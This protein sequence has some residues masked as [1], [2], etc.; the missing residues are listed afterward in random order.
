MFF[1]GSRY[2][3]LTT[4]QVT[5]ADG[6]TVTVTQLP[7]PSNPPL[8][9]AYP[10]QNGQRLDLIASHFLNDATAFWQLCDANDSM[11]PDALAVQNLI[12]IPGSSPS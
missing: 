11:V 8:L 3:N 2:Y 6:T 12:S 4:Y 5:K 9:G 1:P 10:R 7:L